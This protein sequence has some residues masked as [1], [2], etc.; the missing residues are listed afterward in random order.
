[1]VH[2]LLQVLVYPRKLIQQYSVSN[3]WLLTW[4]ITFWYG[5]SDPSVGEVATELRLVGWLEEL[6]F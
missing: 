5:R 4:R 6:G 1:M 3:V 2:L